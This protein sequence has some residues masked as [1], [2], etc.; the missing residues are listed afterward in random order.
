M[1]P[2]SLGLCVV[3]V[4]LQP[5]SSQRRRRHTSSPAIQSGPCRFTP[6]AH[7][8]SLAYSEV[9]AARHPQTHRAQRRGRRA[10]QL[11][12]SALSE[13]DKVWRANLVLAVLHVCLADGNTS[14]V[15]QVAVAVPD[16]AGQAAKRLRRLEVS[17]LW[18]QGAS[19]DRVAC[20]DL[21]EGSCL[22]ACAL[23]SPCYSSSSSSGACTRSLCTRRGC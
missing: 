10:R 21:R 11:V 2:V 20:S 22:T 18:A 8:I 7:V 12:T 13:S 16:V 9:A 19:L 5:T 17:L 4:G 15:S 6:V 23:R 3:A 14:S 1:A